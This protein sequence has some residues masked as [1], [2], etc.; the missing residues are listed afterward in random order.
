[1]QNIEEI[2]LEE[3]RAA[4]K[5]LAGIVV[6]TPLLRLNVEDAPAEI[7]LKVESLQP[8]GSFKIRGAGNALLAADPQQLRGGVWTASAGNMAQGLAWHARRMGLP[9]TIVLPEHAME[10]KVAALRRMGCHILHIPYDTW[11]Q[12]YLTHRYPGLDGLFVHAFAGLPVIAGNG[13]IGLEIL[14]DLP[15]VDSVV[16]P[17]GGGGLSCGVAAALRALKP[18]VRVYG[19]EVETAAPLAAALAEGGPCRIER[20]PS[21]VD[22]IGAVQVTPEMWPLASQLLRGSLV[23][24]LSEVASAIRLLVERNCLVA[25]GA[26]GT[27]VA[28]ALAGKAGGGK[29]VCVLSGGNLDAAKLADILRG[30]IPAPA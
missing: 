28:A 19:S 1:M 14:E 20:I 16:L 10:T 11:W 22:G 26:A 8:V 12:I 13:T 9:C 27:S 30:Q 7:Y 4:Q 29:V 21:F 23:V 17:Y 18:S 6:R 3:I 25:E 24:S 2:S 5:R 15:D